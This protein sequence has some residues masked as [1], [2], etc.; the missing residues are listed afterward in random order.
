MT[1]NGV[2]YRGSGLGSLDTVSTA[3]SLSNH[4][5]QWSL[6]T[7]GNWSSQTIDG[8]ARSRTH[9]SK[10]QVTVVGTNNLTFDNNGNT[11][12]DQNGN[13]LKYDAWNRLVSVTNSGSTVLASYGYDADGWRIRETHGS[14]TT[15]C[16]FTNQWQPIEERQSSTVTNQY[17]WSQAYIDGLVLRDDNSTSGNLGIS[18]S[19]LG[20]RMYAQQDANWDTAALVDTSGA[21]QERFAYDPHGNVTVLT[22]SGNT[23]T[24]SYN[25]VYLH[26]GGRMDPVTG[27]YHFD[28]RDYGPGL[29]RWYEQDLIGGIVMMAMRGSPDM[30]VTTAGALRNATERIKSEL[31]RR[32]VHDPVAYMYAGG[33]D[34][35]EADFSN[36]VDFTDPSGLHGAGSGVQGGG[37]SK[38]CPPRRMVSNYELVGGDL[39]SC[40]D[41][42]VGFPWEYGVGGSILGLYPPIGIGEIFGGLADVLIAQEYCEQGTCMLPPPGLP[43]PP[44]HPPGHNRYGLAILRGSTERETQ[45]FK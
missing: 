8:T 25:W 35:Y 9:N 13:T 29:G 12:T 45:G 20:R 32:S 27:L 44:R 24:D 41:Q 38:C 16:Y 36:P 4:N 26:Q 14:A 42:I 30:D 40:M 5:E 11:S 31:G 43:P 22:A 39:Q 2:N 19:G 37:G 3:S 1:T 34:L 23:T 21:V 33:A 17:I 15:D 7:L 18:G 28:H 6:D 10:N